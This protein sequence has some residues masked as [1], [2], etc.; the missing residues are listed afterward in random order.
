MATANIRTKIGRY[1][2]EQKEKIT[3][4][5]RLPF[6]LKV[7]MAMIVWLSVYFALPTNFVFQPF[8]AA[9]VAFIVTEGVTITIKKKFSEAS[10][11]LGEAIDLEVKETIAIVDF[12]SNK[13]G[14]ALISMHKKGKVTIKPYA[15]A[16]VRSVP[17]ENLAYMLKI[18][19]R[20][21][22]LLSLKYKATIITATDYELLVIQG[23]PI[24]CK[25]SD[26]QERIEE[27]TIGFYKVTNDMLATLQQEAH[28]ELEPLTPEAI[29]EVY[30]AI[31]KTYK[32]R[33][34]N[35]RNKDLAKKPDENNEELET[36]DA[37][38]FDEALEETLDEEMGEL[39]Q[40]I[41]QE[42]EKPEPTEEF[43]EVDQTTETSEHDNDNDEAEDEQEED[44]EEEGSIENNTVNRETED[45]TDENNERENEASQFI[46]NMLIQELN[47][48]LNAF[49]STAK[50]FYKKAFE[51]Q[52][53]KEF[54]IN[55]EAFLK[56]TEL[57]YKKKA[58]EYPY[59][60][61]KELKDLEEFI[62]I[63]LPSSQDMEKL[64]EKIAIELANVNINNKIELK[65]FLSNK[66]DEKEK[67]QAIVQNGH[68]LGVK[69]KTERIPIPS[70]SGGGAA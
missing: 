61:Y 36:V 67:K 6:A 47:Y 19:E 54:N 41:V 32:T 30:P 45:L 49:I 26:L 4:E 7:F 50:S 33:D 22:L 70:S 44:N 57:F 21:R 69:P 64:I 66:Y 14:I 29:K 18:P 51:H 42:N 11:K 9:V 59:K 63:E 1:I 10:E 35:Q 37:T 65:E 16:N 52:L 31:T 25:L 3:K 27:L 34:I 28:A 39:L 2:S 8:I 43:T 56:T 53:E 55:E 58:A 17:A 23:Q 68:N 15:V 38:E 60:G 12:V 24:V 62:D 5:A 20:A 40:S 48:S 13:Y 46:K